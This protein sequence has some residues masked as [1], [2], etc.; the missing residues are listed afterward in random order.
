[1]GATG[2]GIPPVL[3]ALVQFDGLGPAVAVVVFYVLIQ[4]MEGYFI[5]PYIVGRL[6]SINPLAILLAA[7][8]WGWLWGP[9]GLMLAS[10][11]MVC[12]HEIGMHVAYLRPLAILLGRGDGLRVESPL[13][14][15]EAGS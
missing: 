12:F 6:T 4:T 8:L 11:M 1:V 9:M 10:P 15:R 5:T 2:A 7:I 13:G 3:M 14:G